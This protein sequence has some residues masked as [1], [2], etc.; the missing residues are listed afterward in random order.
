MLLCFVQSKKHDKLDSRNFVWKRTSNSDNIS[1]CEIG[2]DT[3]TLSLNNSNID[4]DFVYWVIKTPCL[5]CFLSANFHYVKEIHSDVSSLLVLAKTIVPASQHKW[6]LKKIF[7]NKENKD[8][9]LKVHALHYANELLKKL[10]QTSRYT[11]KLSKTGFGYEIVFFHNVSWQR[12]RKS[13]RLQLTRA[14][15]I[16]WQLKS[17]FRPWKTHFFHQLGA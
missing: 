6:L 1:S 5:F 3:I 4:F 8:L 7:V 10:L 14:D 16:H 13:L 12:K 17:W 11:K 9:D 2:K 15:I